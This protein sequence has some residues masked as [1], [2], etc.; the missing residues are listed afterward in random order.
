MKNNRPKHNQHASLAE[1][2]SG[3]MW[4]H[5]TPTE[6]G[7]GWGWYNGCGWVATYNA[8]LLLGRVIHPAEII[9]FYESVNGALVQGMFGLNPAAV[10][11]F[12]R[13]ID[14][15][16]QTH[17]MPESVDDLIRGSTVSILLYMRDDV[18]AHF[19]TVHYDQALGMFRV[20]NDGRAIAADGS[21][22]A[23]LEDD[24][25]IGP[26][27]IPSVDE[28]LQNNLNNIWRPLTVTTLQ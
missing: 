26:A 13:S 1:K 11:M 17:N 16:Q 27:V 28:W 5:D 10:G 8:A 19:V 23:P 9:R 15:M 21:G 22:S 25:L 7:A 12:F 18:S 24:F 20:F 4:G 14:V 2:A 6:P 3:A